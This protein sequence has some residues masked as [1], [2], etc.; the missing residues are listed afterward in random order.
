MKCVV[1]NQMISNSFQLVCD[2]CIKA[3]EDYELKLEREQ[4]E[5]IEG[6]EQ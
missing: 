5:E 4:Y 1:C 6:V 3:E 2:S